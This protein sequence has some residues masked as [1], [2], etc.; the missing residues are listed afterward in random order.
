MPWNSKYRDIK[1]DKMDS[2]SGEQ[3]RLEMSFNSSSWKI[4]GDQHDA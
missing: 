3:T 4:A 2:K 1:A